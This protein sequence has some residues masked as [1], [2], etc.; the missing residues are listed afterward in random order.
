MSERIRWLWEESKGW[1]EKGLISPDQAGRIRG[2][3]PDG[4]ELIWHGR[5]A[6]RA[7]NP[8]GSVD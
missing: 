5:L 8:W 4:A 1:V 6:S 2:L 7:F 3:Y